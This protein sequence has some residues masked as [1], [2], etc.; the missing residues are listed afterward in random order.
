MGHDRGDGVE[1][2]DNSAGVYLH[3]P[4]CERKCPYCDF[5]TFGKEHGWSS[6]AAD[7][8]EALVGEI[9]ARTGSASRPAIDTIY[10]GGGTPSLMGP[11]ALR[12]L[13]GVLGERF[14]VAEGAEV[15]LEVNPTTAEGAQLEA[16]LAAGVNRLSVGCQSFN[17]RVLARLGRVH[18]AATTRRALAHMRA[19]N[20]EN[21]SLDV[22]V[23]APTQTMEDLETDLGELLA[24]APEHLSVY[25]LT[26]HEGTPY[27]RWA[28]EGRLELPEEDLAAT[29]LE[30][31]IER[32][33]EA[34]YVHYEISNWARPG[35]EARHNSKYWRDC[36]VWGF[37]VGAHGVLGGVRL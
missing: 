13:M 29:M 6:H 36:D 23:A 22:I 18:D 31:M 8:L 9:A 35:M 30:R 21:L 10:F 14:T 34:G 20:I 5:Y 37:G 12:R 4:F 32:L 17:D 3:W 24:F 11:E 19:L 28:K 33:A 2:I 25:N 26:I 1:S 27:A 7:Y 16:M 15:T